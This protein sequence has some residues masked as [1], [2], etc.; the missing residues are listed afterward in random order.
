MI[1]SSCLFDFIVLVWPLL[2]FEGR[3]RQYS[4]LGVPI[5][6]GGRCELLHKS[7]PENTRNH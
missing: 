6:P 2:R 4:R 3:L 5:V 7:S 1:V